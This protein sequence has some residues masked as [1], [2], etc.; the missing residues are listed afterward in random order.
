MFDQFIRGP[1]GFYL[2]L[3]SRENLKIMRLY[4]SAFSL[5]TLDRVLRPPGVKL[6]LS[7]PSLKIS[8]ITNRKYNYGEVLTAHFNWQDIVDYLVK[9]QNKKLVGE[10]AARSKLVFKPHLEVALCSLVWLPL[11]DSVTLR[12]PSIPLNS[13][14]LWVQLY[15]WP[16]F[17]HY[18]TRVVRASYRAIFGPSQG[19][20]CFSKDN[21]LKPINT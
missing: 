15:F 10:A 8:T 5:T 14:W 3:V 9:S 19:P 18:R 20:E 4:T 6:F 1:C 2:W 16:F 11:K 12:P 13:F 21:L 7:W 17:W